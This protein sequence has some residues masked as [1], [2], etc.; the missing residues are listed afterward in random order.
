MKFDKSNQSNTNQ[1]QNRCPNVTDSISIQLSS[2]NEINNRMFET[3]RLLRRQRQFD[4]F[5]FIKVNHE[6]ILSRN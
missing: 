1:V 6:V 2:I 5:P 4:K 3:I